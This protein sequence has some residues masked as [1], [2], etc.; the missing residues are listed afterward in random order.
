MS[1]T[2]TLVTLLRPWIRR[3]TIIIS[4]W[5][6]RTSSKFTWEEVKTSTGKLG[7]WSTPKRVRIRPKYSAPSL[8]RDRRIKMHQSINQSIMCFA[9][10]SKEMTCNYNHGW[11]YGA[12]RWYGTPQ[13]LLRSTVRL[14]CNGTGTVRWYAL[15]IKNP[16]LFAHYAGFL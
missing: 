13:F 11:Q 5:W 2:R 3:F 14:F 8:S 16:R 4:A 6:L 12:V 10:N 9:P 15:L 1:S 7:K